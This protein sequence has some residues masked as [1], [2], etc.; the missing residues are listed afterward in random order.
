MSSGDVYIY[1]IGVKPENVERLRELVDEYDIMQSILTEE[2]D[3]CKKVPLTAQMLYYVFIPEHK[4]KISEIVHDNT[5]MIYL[6]SDDYR[7]QYEIIGNYSLV[8]VKELFEIAFPKDEYNEY[9]K[10]GEF[11]QHLD[12]WIYIACSHYDCHDEWKRRF[13]VR[14]YHKC[15]YHEIECCANCSHEKNNYCVIDGVP[16]SPAGYCN[17]H[18]LHSAFTEE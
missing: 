14:D 5:W 2:L 12:E 18:D 3:K 9:W 7:D 15:D 10:S 13:A 16:I 11:L 17:E 6:T 1:G 4:Y 8:K